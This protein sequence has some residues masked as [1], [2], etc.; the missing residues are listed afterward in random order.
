[1][2]R[3]KK[4]VI[5]ISVLFFAISNLRSETSPFRFLIYNASARAAA[6]GGAFEA[7]INDP[8]SVFYNPATIYTVQ[9]KK[10]SA[11]FLKHVLDINSGNITYIKNIE[12]TGL[13]AASVVYTSN[14]AFNTA[15]NV[16]YQDGS[17]FGANSLSMAVSYANELDTNLFYGVSVKYIFE[18]LQK[19]NSSAFAIDAGLIYK[20]RDGRTNLGLSVLNAGGMIK[21]FDGVSE[22]V[23]IDIRIGM[24][25]RL[26]G[27]PLL[28]CASFHHLADH[29]ESFID[30]LANF[31]VGGE[32]YVGKYV[33]I[34]LGYD[35]QIRRETSPSSDRKLAGLSLGL[36]IKTKNVNFDYGMVQMGG[37]SKLH[38]FSL[39]FDM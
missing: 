2:S 27:L 8:A 29:T 1:M 20:L 14:G 13:F 21:S 4:S 30:K 36:G 17:T 31:S 33:M 32:L 24:N 34:R 28:F 6:M 3:L 38:R 16:G 35:N 25:H 39:A 9:D 37:G 5:L 26:R 11:T 18:N 19:Y 12:N 23:P 10:F 7:V 22:N 15:D